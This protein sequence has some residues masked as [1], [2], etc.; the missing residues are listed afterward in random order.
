[1]IDDPGAVEERL[2]RRKL[3][4][5]PRQ[6]RVFRQVRR[7]SFKRKGMGDGRKQRIREK[8]GETAP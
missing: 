4:F 7:R 1:M 5:K 6:V 2:R 3:V 8:Y